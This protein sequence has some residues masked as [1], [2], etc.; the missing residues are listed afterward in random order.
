M[1]RSRSLAAL[2]VCT[3]MVSAVDPD[4]DLL[5]RLDRKEGPSPTAVI[6]LSAG[7]AAFAAVVAY[8]TLIMTMHANKEV[9]ADTAI[10]IFIAS[11]AALGTGYLKLQ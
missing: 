11:A 3:R 2:A 6:V 7:L 5:D 1:R 9:A 10:L 8:F 4:Q